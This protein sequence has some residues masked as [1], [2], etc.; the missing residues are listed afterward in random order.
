MSEKSEGAI[1]HGQSRD[2]GNNDY[3]RHRINQQTNKQKQQ[4]QTSKQTIQ[5][6]Q[7][8]Q[9]QKIRSLQKNP[10]VTPGTEKDKQ[11]LLLIRN[12]PCCSYSQVV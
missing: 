4:Q 5:K 8:K 6:Q 2:T 3:I 1:K 11:F 9:Q 7:K 10:R 12:Q